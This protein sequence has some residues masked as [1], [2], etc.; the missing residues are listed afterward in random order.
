MK[1]T[2]ICTLLALTTAVSCATRQAEKSNKGTPEIN[3]LRNFFTV[4]NSDI[5][6]AIKIVTD[7]KMSANL[8]HLRR[9]DAGGKKYYLLERENLSEMIMSVTEGT[10]T[11]L[12]LINRSGLIV[13]TMK[14]DNIFGKNVRSHL[15]DTALY[16]CYLK[17][18]QGFHIEDISMFPDDSG[19]PSVFV[20]YPD[21]TDG[22]LSGI[23]IIQIRIDIIKNI[24]DEKTIIIGEDGTYRLSGDNKN[25][26]KPYDYFSSID[27][28]AAGKKHFRINNKKY[29]YYPVD[30]YNLKWIVINRD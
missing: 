8:T 26:Y 1:R 3:K 23:F 18:A 5:K 19:S 10:Y 15:K 28:N 17:G 24:M 11:D 2:I 27:I 6:K 30:I 4:C 29:T 12:I 7:Y 25:L 9:M 13:Y 16:N 20:A 21:K 22:H 14:N